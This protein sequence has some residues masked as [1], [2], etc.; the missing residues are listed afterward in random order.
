MVTGDNKITAKA[1]AIECG[2]LTNEI[3]GVLEGK[4]FM[5]RVG[6]LVCSEC[7]TK[8]CPC[9]RDSGK[10]QKGQKVRKDVIANM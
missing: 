4:E 9:A 7:R 3:G 5:S 8:E 6:G 1:I 2:I 10:A